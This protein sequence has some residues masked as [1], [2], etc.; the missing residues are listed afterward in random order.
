MKRRN[1]LDSEYSER[2]AAV[3]RERAEAQRRSEAQ[4]LAQQ[5]QPITDGAELSAAVARLAGRWGLKKK[6]RTR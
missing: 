1:D 3:E 4:R 6:A 2:A 5:A